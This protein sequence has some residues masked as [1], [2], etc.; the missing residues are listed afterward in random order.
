MMEIVCYSHSVLYENTTAVAEIHRQ[1]ACIESINGL[2]K[3]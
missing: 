3:N 2:S 1:S